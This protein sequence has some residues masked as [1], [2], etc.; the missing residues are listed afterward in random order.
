MIALSRGGIS[1]ASMAVRGFGAGAVQSDISV[2]ITDSKDDSQLWADSLDGGHSTWYTGD[3]IVSHLRQRMPKEKP[4]EIHTPAL[5]LRQFALP[6]QLSYDLR[7][8]REK[9]PK[10]KRQGR[11][12]RGLNVGEFSY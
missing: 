10:I 9:L 7:V 4:D 8:E 2:R 6:L 5:R 12:V 11:Q 1:G 3:K